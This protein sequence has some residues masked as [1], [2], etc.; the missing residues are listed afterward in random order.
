MPM[1]NLTIDG[2]EIQ[3]E[4]GTTILEAAKKANI[5]IPTLC[6]LKDINVVGACRICVVEVA[7]ARTLMASCVTP[8]AEKMVVRTN[9]PAVRASRRFTL[10]L[11]LSNHPFL[12]F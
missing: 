11:I 10:E 5:N 8:V 6:Y 7:G 12:K 2:R 4:E 1:V 9:S 3:A